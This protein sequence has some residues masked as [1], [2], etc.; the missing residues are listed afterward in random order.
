MAIPPNEASCKMRNRSSLSRNAISACLRSVISRQ[1]TY[2]IGC[3][4]QG[5]GV[6][7]TSTQKSEPSK[8]RFTH[9]NCCPPSRKALA[10]ISSAFS[11]DNRPSG[12]R[13]GDK[14]AGQRWITCSRVAAPSIARTVSLQSINCPPS[15]SKAPSPAFSN[16]RRNNCSRSCSWRVRVSTNASARRRWDTVANR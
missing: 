11:V 10:T 16:I 1:V 14:S 2:K 13:A 7:C 12:W 9:S 4:C 3:P 6:S 8:R 15:I 5:T